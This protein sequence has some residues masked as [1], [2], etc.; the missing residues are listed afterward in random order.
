M[1]FSVQYNGAAV[2]PVVNTAKM[3]YPLMLDGFESESCEFYIGER[4]LY[5][6]V[7]IRHSQAANTHPQGVSDVHTIG[8]SVIPLQEA[9]LVRIKPTRPLT[10]AEQQRTVMQWYSGSK[11]DVQK[12]EWKNG[13]ASA[14]FRDFGAFRLVTDEIPPQ[15]IAP[16][17]VDGAN[18]SKVS[19]ITFTVTD[20][21]GRGKNVRTMLDGKW[22]RFTNDKGR[23][24]IYRF[25]EKCPPGDHELTITAED[26]A[27]NG[28]TQTFRFVR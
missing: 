28:T 13:W 7:H 1:E 8:S 3:F 19:R 16:G 5:D 20:N 14:R 2:V 27:G 6:S 18:L 11:N 21:L 17:L 15:I 10:V 25:D 4:C 26:E 9:M 23:T 12:V 22:L 24:F